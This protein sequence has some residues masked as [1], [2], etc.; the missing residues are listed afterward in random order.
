M[1]NNIYIGES[2]IIKIYLGS[3]LFNDLTQDIIDI[4]DLNSVVLEGT[5]SDSSLLG[6]NNT[7]S[8]YSR[9]T[10]SKAT[11]SCYCKK[12]SNYDISV[13]LPK[14][15]T[16][17]SLNTTYCITTT[18]G[19]WKFNVNQ[20]EDVNMWRKIGTIKSTRGTVLKIEV[21]VNEISNNRI[22]CIKIE[23]TK[24]PL[25]PQY[26]DSA[27]Q[28]RETVSV[29]SNQSGYDIG[30]PK[31]ATITNVKD[32]TE[33]NIIDIS[34]N[35]IKYTGTVLN[36]IADFTEFEPSGEDA[37]Y[38]I[39]C[40]D[41]ESYDF[42]IK[43]NYIQDISLLPALKF[44][45]ESRQDTFDVGGN[46]GYGWRDSHQFS[47]ELNSLVMQYM[48][49]PSY[50]KSLS[51][52]ISN[53]DTCEYEELRVQTEPSIVWL[54]KFGALRYYDWAKNK[55]VKLHA[56]IKGQLAYFLY[57]YPYIKEYVSQEFYEKIRTITIEQWGISECNKTWYEVDGVDNNL[58]ATQ[59]KIGTVKGQL[60]PGYAIVPN[61]LMWEVAKRDSLKNADDYFN[62]FYNNCKWLVDEVDLDKPE[63]TKGQRMSEYITITG[64]TY[65]YE[66]YPELCPN[67]TLYKINRF[68]DVMISRSNNLWDLRQYSTKGDLT[69]SMSTVWTGGG[70]MNE[71]GNVA[72]FPAICYSIIRVINDEKKIKR[73]RELATSHIDNI[74]GRNPY[75]RHYGYDAP[76]EIE[77]VNVG[78]FEKYNG[79]FGNLQNVF[80]RLDGS[81]KEG[82]YPF[83]PRAS[84]GYTEGWVAFNTAWNTS[85]A[86]LCGEN[87]NITDGI[88]IFA[89]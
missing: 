67:G 80:G 15:D 39:K 56:L 58:F 25:S 50:Y 61:L 43:S 40:Q 79:G 6:Y 70:T 48:S 59:N 3:T 65:A 64:L 77:G 27:N 72:G 12:T 83:N 51:H 10:G 47:F 49:N 5:W 86:Y 29:F 16:D 84:Y 87:T 71:V 85:L 37:Q 55:G 62:A 42:K 75:R 24:N 74:F 30:K 17:N 19:Y 73:L 33:F 60:P 68:A 34:D 28:D 41:V 82:A 78:W 66:T 89:K 20:N 21:L 18:D 35:T 13:W 76:T 54:M 36:Q 7:S 45:D 63:Y 4:Y 69:G 81:P 32:G 46:T 9:E 22:N 23:T 31:R 2:P 38:K 1:S 14:G 44:M 57:L 52:T 11:W 88:G 53:L 26:D 8:K